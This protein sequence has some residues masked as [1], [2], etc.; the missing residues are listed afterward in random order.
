VELEAPVRK[1]LE[2]YKAM[3]GGGL[4]LSDPAVLATI[5]ATAIPSDQNLSDGPTD[6]V[7]ISDVV[8]DDVPVRL[9]RP[10]A[11]GRL[12]LHVYFHGGG[13]VVGSAL[14]G[15]M[16]GLLARRALAANCIVA[17]VEYR[18]APEYLFP[19]AANDCYAAFEGL[20]ANAE[21]YGIARDVVTLGGGSAGG[22]LAAVVALMA[23]DKNGPQ[24]TLQLVEIA[25]VDFTNSSHAWRNPGLGHDTTR[26]ADVAWNDRHI[27]TPAERVNP[28]V[29]P[30]F[31]ADLAGVAPAYF[32]NAEF[33][34][35]RD[36]CEAYVIR[37]RDAG[38]QAV[39][40][41]MKGHVHGS[42]TIPDWQP[43]RD[44]RTEV[45]AVLASV[46]QATLAGRPI[47]LPE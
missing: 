25:G 10:L 41:T 27:S 4:D 31:A 32:V 24:I 36:E 26:E 35:R 46:N 37:L 38:V 3:G 21:Q 33:D 20:I 11:E 9:Y 34:P 8:V 16:D 29:S 7:E 45:N 2:T 43:A 14:G 22:N 19:A 1:L 5:R 40:R 12:P 13:F 17:S 18:L 42:V 15:E 28:Y 23:R 6:G 30:F 39:A 47:E 44:W